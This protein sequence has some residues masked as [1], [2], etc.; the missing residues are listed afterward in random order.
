[1]NIQN[2]KKIKH[3]KWNEFMKLINENRFFKK[4]TKPKKV[5]MVV[6]WNKGNSHFKSDNEKFLPIKTA[7]EDHSGNIIVLPEAKFTQ[8]D[9]TDILGQFSDYENHYKV[10]PGAI[11][12]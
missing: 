5:F 8:K 10:I 2:L 1:M 11:K 6:M 7:I 9:E 3:K 4:Q 12:P